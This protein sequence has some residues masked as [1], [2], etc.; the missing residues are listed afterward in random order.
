MD[1]RVKNLEQLDSRAVPLPH[2]TEIVT[3]VDAF[4][5]ERR[6][7]QGTIGRVTKL[8]GDAVDVTVVGIGVVRYTRAQLS[9]RRVGQALFAHRRADAWSALSGCIVR[10]DGGIARVGARACGLGRGSP[11]CLRA[12]V[13]V[14]AWARRA[15]RGPRQRRRQ[16]DVLGGG[17]GDPPGAARRS[18]HARDAVRARR[19]C[20]RS[21]RRMAA[22]RARCLRLDGD[23]RHVRALC[24]RPATCFAR[25]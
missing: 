16:R 9:P 5:G 8:E 25:R 23:L 18:K 24:A 12:S 15:A 13:R 10:H 3:R 1:L 2:G 11:R 21:E 14:D 22:R 19:A 20:G 4:L 7:P 17:Q 6:I